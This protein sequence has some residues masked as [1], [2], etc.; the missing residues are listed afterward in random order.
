MHKNSSRGWG[1]PAVNNRTN[2]VTLGAATP[3][4][5]SLEHKVSEEFL[6]LAEKFGMEPERL[7]SLICDTFV[8]AKPE[9]LTIIARFAEDAAETVH[10]FLG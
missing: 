3:R 5:P 2:D 1:R 8:A 9:M 6:G 10:P 4:M 7:A